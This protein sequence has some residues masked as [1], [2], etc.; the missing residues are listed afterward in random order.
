MSFLS[1]RRRP[2]PRL[3]RD[4]VGFAAVAAEPPIVRRPCLHGAAMKIR[5]IWLAVIG[6]GY[7]A[8]LAIAAPATHLFI[9]IPCVDVCPGTP[10]YFIVV[11]AGQTQPLLVRAL[12]ASTNGLA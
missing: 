3:Q 2:N 9:A 8:R 12:D 6:L 5:P 7:A 10:T 4:A 1:R 11:Q